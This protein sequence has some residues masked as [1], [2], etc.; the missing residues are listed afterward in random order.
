MTYFKVIGYFHKSICSLS[1]RIYKLL[2]CYIYRCVV[3]YNSQGFPSSIFLSSNEISFNVT[4]ESISR[5]EV[6]QE[7]WCLNPG[8]F[9][10]KHI[11]CFLQSFFV[12]GINLYTY[13]V[14]PTTPGGS[15]NRVPR[16]SNS[17]SNANKRYRYRINEKYISSIILICSS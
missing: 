17:L 4:R 15:H 11:F 9:D 6:C 8:D 5:A 3:Q 14:K 2:I 10:I 16:F 1:E 7:E 13:F 12:V